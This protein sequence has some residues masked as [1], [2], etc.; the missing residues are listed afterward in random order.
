M[1]I[2]Y[3]SIVYVMKL[4]LIEYKLYF[5]IYFLGFQNS[6]SDVT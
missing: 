4:K 1:Y 3:Y 5:V 2:Y 6:N